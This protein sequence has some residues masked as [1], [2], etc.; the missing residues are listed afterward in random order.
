MLLLIPS[1]DNR[2]VGG[3]GGADEYKDEDEDEF[4]YNGG[5]GDDSSTA[6]TNFRATKQKRT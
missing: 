4:G 2:R 1:L 5:V 3:T 6:N